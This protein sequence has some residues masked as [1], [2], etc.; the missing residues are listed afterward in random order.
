MIEW[1]ERLL[2]K[3]GENDVK[4]GKRP[5]S[6]GGLAE[7]AVS[8]YRVEVNP[9][10]YLNNRWAGGSVSV[11]CGSRLIFTERG[12]TP[13]DAQVA[14]TGTTMVCYE[15]RGRGIATV[16][17]FFDGGGKRIGE[18]RFEAISYSSGISENGQI[19]VAQFANSG[20]KDGG[21]LVLIDVN[22]FKTIERLHLEGGWAESYKIYPDER[23]FE[24]RYSSGRAYRYA[25]NGD[26]LDKELF[27]NDQIEYGEPTVLVQMVRWQLDQT[28]ATVEGQ[29]AELLAILDRADARGLSQ[30]RDWHAI[31]LRARGEILESQGSIAEAIMAYRWALERNPK[32]GVRRKLA[33]LERKG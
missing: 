23:V 6:E 31:A 14:A 33:A 19:A 10:H 32:I 12:G 30:Y 16:V 3:T 29:H 24:A 22:Q 11:F 7:Q 1:L 4:D 2:G 17:R 5:W 9:A 27:R 21:A 13:H 28:A 20:S 18:L 8:K 15:P 26:F 25:F